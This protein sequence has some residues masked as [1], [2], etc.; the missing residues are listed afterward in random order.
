MIVTCVYIQVKPEC[1][2]SFLEATGIN[3][4]NSV[5]EP[6]NLRFDILQEVADPCRFTFYEAYETEEAAAAHKETSHYK[7]WKSTVEGYMAA[8]RK[9]VKH[10]VIQPTDRKQ[11]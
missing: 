11:W 4:L 2:Y 8:S 9:G 1:I 5:K 7:E 6:G 10:L 3:H